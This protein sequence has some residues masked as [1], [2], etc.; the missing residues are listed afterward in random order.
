MTILKTVRVSALRYKKKMDANPLVAFLLFVMIVLLIP[1]LIG[2]VAPMLDMHAVLFITL[3]TVLFFCLIAVLIA[4]EPEGQLP[5]DIS[6]GNYTIRYLN[7]PQ[8]IHLANAITAKA[9]Q[10][11]TID[12]THVQGILRKN[13][14]ACLGIFEAR[15]GGRVRVLLA[16]SR[17][18]VPQVAS[19][20][21][22]V[23]RHVGGG[24][25]RRA[26]PVGYRGRQ[27]G[28]VVHTLRCGAGSSDL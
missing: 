28:R 9:F 11:N 24:F 27:G 12:G 25:S 3:A 19:R 10:D 4:Q 2:V 5:E 26:Y 1:T 21:R 7:T 22:R 17:R 6:I 14:N 13:K 18:G 15:D 23:R 8:Q 20:R 16:H